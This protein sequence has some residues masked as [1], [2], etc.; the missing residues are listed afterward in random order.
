MTDISMAL[1]EY[2]RKNGL[3]LDANSLRRI[4]ARFV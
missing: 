1:L 4:L 2:L 3:D